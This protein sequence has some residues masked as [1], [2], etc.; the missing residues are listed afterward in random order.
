MAEEEEEE[1]VQQQPWCLPAMAVASQDMGPSP[2]LS[3]CLHQ[4]C[5]R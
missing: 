1:V 2:C 4:R 3:C 5:L